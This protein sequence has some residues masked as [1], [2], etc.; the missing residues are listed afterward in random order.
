M[1]YYS[2]LPKNMPSSRTL[3]YQPI[4]N[5]A[6]FRSAFHIFLKRFINSQTVFISNRLSR[7]VRFI[8]GRISFIIYIDDIS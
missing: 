1:N 3:K 6:D 4:H 7:F 5:K 8:K 2:C